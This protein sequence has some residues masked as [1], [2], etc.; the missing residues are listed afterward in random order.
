GVGQQAEGEGAGLVGAGGGG[1]ERGERAGEAGGL[2]I[3]VVLAGVEV[4]LGA[5]GGLGGGRQRV[6]VDGGGNRGGLFVG[7]DHRH[8]V[9]HGD[10]EGAGD[11]AV[12]GCAVAVGIGHGCG[13]DGREVDGVDRVAVGDE[14]GGGI[15]V[16][17]DMIELVFEV[18]G[19]GAVG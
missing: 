12:G 14:G 4:A 7:D 3:G 17:I 8:V 5:V 15:A 13:D 10:G 18:E 9:L 19:P 2:V 11:E 6:F 16:G 1:D